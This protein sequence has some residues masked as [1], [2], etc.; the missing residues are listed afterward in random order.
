MSEI[1]LSRDLKNALAVGPNRVQ[2]TKPQPPAGAPELGGQI[3]NLSRSIEL[4]R[5]IEG[6]P[7]RVIQC[8]KRLQAELQSRAL[9]AEPNILEQAHIPIVQSRAAQPV[10]PESIC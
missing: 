7:L 2:R 8:V 3:H 5:V 10:K 4:D 6:A 9:L 1:Q